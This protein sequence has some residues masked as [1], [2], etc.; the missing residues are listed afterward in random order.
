MVSSRAALKLVNPQTP[1]ERFQHWLASLDDGP[2]SCR[3]ERG[4]RHDMPRLLDLTEVT[5]VRRRRGGVYQIEAECKVCGL[6][7]TLTTGRG[8][9][10]DG[11][12]TWVYDY[13][14]VPGYLAPRG[15]GRHRT[16]DFRVELGERAAPGIR[17]A[18]A[19]TSARDSAAKRTAA[20]ARAAKTPKV[21]KAGNQHGT[22][23][24]AVK[25]ARQGENK[26]AQEWR[27]HHHQAPGDAS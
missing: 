15:S 22:N 23:P 26:L 27:Q 8:G 18:A 17:E 1:E 21:R 2:L 20:A 9:T 16:A 5:N 19:A 4:G 11:T 3:S 24:R 10:L 7:G 14:A 6:P 12:E 13:H 25:H